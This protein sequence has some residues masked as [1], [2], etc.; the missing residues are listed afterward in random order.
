[1]T[2]TP[3]SYVTCLHI[4]QFMVL[5]DISFPYA[6]P[7]LLEAYA[8]TKYVAPIVKPARLLTKEPTPV[9]SDV[10]VVRAMVGPLLVLQQT[11]FA[12]IVTPPS[13]VTFPPDNAAVDVMPD[14][15]VVIT[16]GNTLPSP[17]RQ[18]TDKPNFLLLKYHIAS[19][20]S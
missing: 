7:T 20:V 1:M 17:W 14:M 9:P 18:R 5:K 10:L 2:I 12:F 8:L 6:V 16:A 19:G 11:H 13:E 3:F 4:I 15:A